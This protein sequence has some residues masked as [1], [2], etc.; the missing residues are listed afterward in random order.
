MD[1]ERGK[2]VINRNINNNF[3]YG[4]A[5]LLYFNN[6]NDISNNSNKGIQISARMMMYGIS[7]V[8]PD[9]ETEYNTYLDNTTGLYS[10]TQEDFTITWP[11]YSN[12]SYIIIN[13]NTNH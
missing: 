8:I 11:S 10:D 6:N 7:K 12:I 3:K 1:C 4:D 9:L 2:S 5:E 13:R